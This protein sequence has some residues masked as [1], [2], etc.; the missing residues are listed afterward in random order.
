MT[1]DAWVRSSWVTFDRRPSRALVNLTDN[2]PLH[3]NRTSSLTNTP[4]SRKNPA[5]TKKE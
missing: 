2:V 4:T 5:S 3:W 1:T